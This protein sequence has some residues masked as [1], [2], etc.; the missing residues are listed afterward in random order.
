MSLVQWMQ[1]VFNVVM[2]FGKASKGWTRRSGHSIYKMRCRLTCR[3]YISTSLMN[4]GG[5]WFDKLLKTRAR[6]SADFATSIHVCQCKHF[7]MK[8][9][10]QFSLHYCD[11]VV[12]FVAEHQFLAALGHV[13]CFHCIHPCSTSLSTEQ[14][15]DAGSCTHI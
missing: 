7:K 2:K 14:G 5:T 6:V 4:V 11:N 10:F 8:Y 3:N 12:Q 1:R 13:A 9:L 15:E